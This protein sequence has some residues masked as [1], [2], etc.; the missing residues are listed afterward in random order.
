MCSRYSMWPHTRYL[1]YFTLIG[2]LDCKVAR[3]KGKVA[4][5][6]VF[7]GI[8]HVAEGVGVTLGLAEPEQSVV[9]P[10]QVVCP[11]GDHIEGMKRTKTRRDEEQKRLLEG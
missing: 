10:D 1:R 2:E 8:G 4:I 7:T 11:K 5:E 6:D 3:V 9:V